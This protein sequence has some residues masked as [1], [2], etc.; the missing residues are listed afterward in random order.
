[1]KHIIT[2]IIL[3]ISLHLSAIY[4]LQD[5]KSELTQEN[6]TTK[7]KKKSNVHYVKLRPPAQ[8]SVKKVKNT[9]PKKEPTKKKILKKEA[10]KKEYKKV[11]KI[12]KQS[13]RK[14]KKVVPKKI[15]RKPIEKV[16]AIPN[17]KKLNPTRFQKETLD[18]FLAKPVLDVKFLD[19]I[20]QSYIK[21]YGEEYNN[22][23]KV[24]KVF[25]QN[26]L[27]SIGRITQKYLKYPRISVRTH[28]QGTNIIEFTLYPN[29]DISE[30]FITNS[31]GYSA[32][33]KNTIETIEIAYKD[34]PR[35]TEPTKIK[36]YVK[37]ILY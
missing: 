13:K 3:S 17:Y 37:Y 21:L 5:K 1:M 2:A 34:Y 29:G 16:E 30:P 25:L 18:S 27:K 7:I 22:F 33:D 4:F 10:E 6:S 24:Q 11:K 36:I 28:Q 15:K 12:I 23:T 35:P 26:S 19:K 32:L 14:I 9:Q 8:K 31:S 20:T